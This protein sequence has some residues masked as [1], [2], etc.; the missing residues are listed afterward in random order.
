VTERL[1]FDWSNFLGSPEFTTDTNRENDVP[2]VDPPWIAKGWTMPISPK[3]KYWL[4]AEYTFPQGLLGSGEWWTRFS[5]TWQGEVWDSLADIED[6]HSD[7]PDDVAAALEYR[8]PEWKSGTFQVGYTS[9]SGGWD[10]AFIVR[11]V[12]DDASYSYL[13]GTNYGEFFGDPRF[14]QIRTL[15]RPISY[16]LSFTKRW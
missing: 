2:G 5:Y 6:F 3:E 13:S 1:S 8:I 9:Q 14:N 4:S 12:F 15:Q 7:D 16:S 10:A 11:N